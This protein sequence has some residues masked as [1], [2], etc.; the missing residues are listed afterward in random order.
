M[1]RFVGIKGL[2][3][4]GKDVVAN[5]IADYL[6][7]SMTAKVSFADPLKE[8]LSIV[9]GIPKD[10]IDHM[11]TSVVPEFGMTVRTM[12]QKIGT[13]AMRNQLDDGVWIKIAERRIRDI[14]RH[15]V[16]I[17]PDVRF[18]NEMEFI[19]MNEGIIL[20]VYRPQRVFDDSVYQH[21]SEMGGFE[22]DYAIIN[23]GSLEDLRRKVYTLMGEVFKT[24][25]SI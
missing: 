21:I 4:H 13:D 20:N 23:D 9:S 16:V 8:I 14:P 1:P 11:K 25:S 18:E 12:L 6:S 24:Y 7:P 5:M 10:R 19:H 2:A 15:K 17:F 3:G 22:A